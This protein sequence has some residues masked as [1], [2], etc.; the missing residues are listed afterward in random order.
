MIEGVKNKKRA[1]GSMLHFSDLNICYLE[2]IS[3]SIKELTSGPESILYETVREES[4]LLNVKGHF[5]EVLPDVFLSTS[6]FVFTLVE[7][8]VIS[9][10]FPTNSFFMLPAHA[11]SEIIITNLEIFSF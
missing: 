10:Y 11:K 1:F 5:L 8:A 6:S 2:W 7:I 3:T 9:M 4:K